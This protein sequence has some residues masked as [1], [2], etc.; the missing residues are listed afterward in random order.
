MSKN[1]E[2][3]TLF[4]SDFYRD[5][6]AELIEI[7]SPKFRYQSPFFGNVDFAEYIDWMSRLSNQ[8]SV[9]AKTALRSTDD[10]IFEYQFILKVLDF[11][12]GFDEDMIGNS[13]IIIKNGLIEY[14]EIT[15]DDEKT[16]SPKFEK[17]KTKLLHE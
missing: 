14:V 15:Y 7:I 9:T 8:R 2:I 11:V 13:K 1:H 17:I 10:E 16:K 3:V 6:R 12:D 4:L 5:K